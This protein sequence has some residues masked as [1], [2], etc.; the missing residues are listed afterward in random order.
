MRHNNAARDA[1]SR[2]GRSQPQR[3]RRQGI[4]ASSSTAPSS[5]CVRADSRL[6]KKVPPT[7][8]VRL[9]LYPKSVG[10]QTPRAKNR[11]ATKNLADDYTAGIEASVALK[12]VLRSKK[13]GTCTP[14]VLSD[15]RK[16]KR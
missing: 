4:A 12:D 8:E 1:T 7:N 2:Q 11:I 15:P 3:P 16:I 6:I 13:T 5:S 14:C 10:C 9:Q